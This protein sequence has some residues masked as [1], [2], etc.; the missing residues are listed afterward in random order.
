M[1]QRGKSEAN[2]FVERI[3]FVT[4]TTFRFELKKNPLETTHTISIYISFSVLV[5]ITI[6][7]DFS[8]CVIR[9]STRKPRKTERSIEVCADAMPALTELDK[10]K[11]VQSEKNRAAFHNI[12]SISRT[13]THERTHNQAYKIYIYSRSVG[14]Y[15]GTISYEIKIMF[16]L[17]LGEFSLFE[18]RFR[19]LSWSYAWRS[20]NMNV[21][22]S[23]NKFSFRQISFAN[24]EHSYNWRLRKQKPIRS[25]ES[26][27]IFFPKLLQTFYTHFVYCM[28]LVI[29]VR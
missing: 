25:D 20:A 3:L 18:F 26:I 11:S 1:R 21:A 14:S 6:S 15:F 24:D 2:I 22:L 7:N 12:L 29:D 10:L 19:L 27:W 13:H 16:T 5:L 28:M 8:F 17:W 4:R 9:S 23:L